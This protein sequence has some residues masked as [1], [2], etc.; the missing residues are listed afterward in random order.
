IASALATIADRAA[1]SRD[2]GDWGVYHLAG[3]EACT[4][5]GFAQAIFAAAEA[6]GRPSPTLTPVTTADYPT[7]ARRAPDTRLATSAHGLMR[8]VSA[9]GYSTRIG[10]VVERL[11]SA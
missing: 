11:L 3:A 5:F 2:A 8:G 6:R 1:A 7:P 10:E 4:W 9:A